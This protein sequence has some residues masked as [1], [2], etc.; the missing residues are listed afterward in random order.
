[1]LGV[2]EGSWNLTTG[3][4]GLPLDLDWFIAGKITFYSTGGGEEIR[5]MVIYSD[6]YVRGL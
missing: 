3:F 2:I 4:G 5:E 1:M 6:D